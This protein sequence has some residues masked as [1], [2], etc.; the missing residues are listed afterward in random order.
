VYHNIDSSLGPRR[1]DMSIEISTERKGPEFSKIHVSVMLSLLAVDSS[2]SIQ[3]NISRVI[4][5]QILSSI[6]SAVN[7]ETFPDAVYPFFDTNGLF[8]AP[9]KLEAALADLIILQRH[10]RLLT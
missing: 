1:T 8:I 10:N 5:C 2:I 6:F 3:C 4:K 7:Y 9:F